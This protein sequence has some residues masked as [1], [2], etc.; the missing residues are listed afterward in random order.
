MQIKIG[1]QMH[2]V[3]EY[4]QPA[5]ASALTVSGV[6][7]FYGVIVKTDGTNDTGTV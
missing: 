6:T 4:T 3:H 2:K 7:I 5:S 1:D